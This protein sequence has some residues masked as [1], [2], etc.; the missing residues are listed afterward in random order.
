M[1]GAHVIANWTPV[2][3]ELDRDRV[4]SQR[5]W[6]DDYPHYVAQ[7]SMNSLGAHLARDIDVGGATQVAHVVRTDNTW[8]LQ[9]VESASLGSFDWVVSTAPAAQTAQLLP[10]EFAYRNRVQ[11]AKLLG[12]YALMLGFAAPLPLDWQTALVR[13]ADISWISVN[14]SKP[15]RPDAFSLVVHSTNRWAEAHMEDELSDVEQ[16]LLAEVSMVI[17]HDASQADYRRVHRW[18]YA[19]IDK[20]SGEPSLVDADNQL[21]AC[22]DWCVRGRVEAAF[23]SAM[24]LAD[25]IERIL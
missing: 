19:N 20:Q 7:P 15:G 10:P 12:C 18:R 5:P 17:G 21:A 16:H 2:F 3:A 6:D 23:T 11:S 14:S 1:V 22:G 25:R 4:L 13:N 9:D 8:A 24:S